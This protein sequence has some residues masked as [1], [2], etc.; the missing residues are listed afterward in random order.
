V[1]RRRWRELLFLYGVVVAHTAVALV[2]FGSIRGRVPVEP[3]IAIFAAVTIDRV[4]FRLRE[5]RSNPR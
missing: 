2:F 1:T 5:R 3:V 4:V